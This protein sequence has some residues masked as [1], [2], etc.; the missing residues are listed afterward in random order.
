VQQFAKAALRF[1]RRSYGGAWNGK[2]IWGCLTHSRV[3]YM[4]KNRV[5]PGNTMVDGSS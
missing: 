2:L 3:L 4:L 1:P 5:R